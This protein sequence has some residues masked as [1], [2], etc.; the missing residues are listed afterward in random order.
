M[1]RANLRPL[2]AAHPRVMITA[3][4]YDQADDPLTDRPGHREKRA[5]R[6]MVDNARQF[7]ARLTE[8]GLHTEAVVFPG[9]THG[10]V[11]PAAIARAVRVVS[12][13][14]RRSSR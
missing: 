4:E 8:A 3:A 2:A 13:E 1:M 6:R 12:H 10:S 14:F 7:A 9:E 11:I 5:A